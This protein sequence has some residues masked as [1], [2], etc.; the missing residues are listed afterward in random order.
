MKVWEKNLAELLHDGGLESPWCK[1]MRL[2]YESADFINV[3]VMTT[4]KKPTLEFMKRE[5][6]PNGSPVEGASVWLAR[7]LKKN[8][9]LDLFRLC[10]YLYLRERVYGLLANKTTYFIAAYQL[11]L[12]PWFAPYAAKVKRRYEEQRDQ[13]RTDRTEQDRFKMKQFSELAS[14]GLFGELKAYKVVHGWSE[15]D[16]AKH[17]PARY[18][19]LLEKRE[20]KELKK[21][22]GS[23]A[24]KTKEDSTS[25]CKKKAGEKGKAKK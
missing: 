19:K 8:K 12:M 15:E 14:T 13:A 1:S 20:A 7:K 4:P 5:N 2:K 6:K 23:G 17:Y 9:P 24:W 10:W 11:T 18:Q 21:K 3:L 22:K 16:Y 25:T